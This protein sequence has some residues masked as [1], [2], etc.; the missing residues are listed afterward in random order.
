MQIVTWNVNSVRSRQQRLLDW[1]GAHEPDV[2]CLQELKCT[3]EQFPSIEVRAAGYHAAVHGQKTYNGVAILAREPLTDV[4]TGFGD[5]EDDA[6]ARL[7]SATV[8]DTRVVCIYVPNGDFVGSK[9]WVF[10]LAWLDRLRAYLERTAKPS[11]RLVVCGDFN[12]APDDLDVADPKRWSASVLCHQD[13]RDRLNGLL[14]WGFLDLFRQQHP[15][16]GEYSWWDYRYRAFPKNVGLRID[17][18]LATGA[19]QCT[20]ASVDRDERAGESPSDH[21]PVIA[22]VS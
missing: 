5:G 13:V 12:I 2:L 11:D 10:K 18:L 8:G 9:K 14:D 7:V 20:A 19:L 16:G 22:E 15:A 6:H 3:D 1:L 21:A 4:S 17:L